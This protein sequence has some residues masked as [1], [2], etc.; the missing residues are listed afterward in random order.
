MEYNHGFA[1]FDQDLAGEDTA[2]AGR[3]QH[4]FGV[5]RKGVSQDEIAPRQIPEVWTTYVER[6]ARVAESKPALYS[7]SNNWAFDSTPIFPRRLEV[8]QSTVLRLT[9]SS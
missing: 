7:L 9:H 4:F 1:S 5:E 8:C 6:L 2:L 3:S